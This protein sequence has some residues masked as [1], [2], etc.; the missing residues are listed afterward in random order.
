MGCIPV[1]PA[2]GKLRQEDHKF[3]VG[4]GCR[5]KPCLKYQKKMRIKRSDLKWNSTHHWKTAL[6]R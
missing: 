6:S 4:L 3:M 1:I 2:L 5:E